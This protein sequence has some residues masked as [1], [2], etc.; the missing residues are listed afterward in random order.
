MIEGA[1]SERISVVPIVRAPSDL[2]RILREM[3]D[4]VDRGE[5]TDFVGVTV[6]GGAYDFHYAASLHSCLV[7]ASMLW[8]NCVDRMR[9]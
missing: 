2:S 4:A 9:R 1:M 6:N 5:I 8:Q 7:M 3:A